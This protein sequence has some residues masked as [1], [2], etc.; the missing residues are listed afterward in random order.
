[1][2]PNL[3]RSESTE[4]IITTAP[5]ELR[6]VVTSKA[7]NGTLKISTSA[8]NSP[9]KTTSVKLQQSS[10]PPTPSATPAPSSVQVGSLS[11]SA[12]PTS[13]SQQG[14]NVAGF[15]KPP[16]K[17]AEDPDTLKRIQ[18]ILDDY[19]EQ[20]RNSP[21]LQNRPAPRRRTNGPPTGSTTSPPP[22]GIIIIYDFRVLHTYVFA[23]KTFFIK[24]KIQNITN[25]NDIVGTVVF[26]I[27]PSFL[28][29]KFVFEGKFASLFEQ[30]SFLFQIS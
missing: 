16:P 13:S 22:P 6:S 29:N 11:A 23:K 25:V 15:V 5:S 28:S 3:K 7:I 20:I 4:S 26:H 18:Q 10:Q 2:G 27:L 14:Q 24:S 30:I 21:D 8:P 17:P 1:M 12:S 19:N 9:V